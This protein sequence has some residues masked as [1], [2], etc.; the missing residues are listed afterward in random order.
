MSAAGTADASRTVGALLALTALAPLDAALVAGAAAVGLARRAADRAARPARSGPTS[1]VAGS[2]T[3]AP[4]R[5]T[6]LLTGGKM[7]K[8][9]H[10]ARAF[11][12]AGHRVV[13]VEE[14]RYRWTAHRFSRCVAAFHVVPGPHD[15]GYA[16]ALRR[17]VLAE[18]VDVVVPVCS[19]ASSVPDAAAHDL[20][21]PHCTLLHPAVDDV[22]AV[23]DK[24]RFAE[25]ASGLGLP[26]PDTHRVT[27][28]EQAVDLAHRLGG[29]GRP[30]YALKSIAYDP[31]HRLDL[32]PLPRPTRA[33]TAAFATALGISEHSPWIPQE[34]VEGVEYCTHGI[35]CAGRLRAFTCCRSSAWQ[36]T[37]EAVDHPGVRDWVQRFVEGTGLTGQLSFDIME[38]PD[39]SVVALECN[40]RPHSAV[41]LFRD[42]AELAAAYLED[43]AAGDPPAEPVLGAPP[44]YWLH[45]E[46]WQLLTRSGS[47]REHLRTLLRGRDA[48]LEPEDPLPFLA[49]WHLHLPSLLVAELRRGGSWLR[50]D[51]NI[52][53]LVQPAGD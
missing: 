8:A 3:A 41:T 23:D 9:L 34:I 28:A 49:L 6:V 16:E 29:P 46:V 12:R 40:P 11:H 36:L 47:A 10:L 19:P 32:T 52:G 43:G 42:P 38:R 31:V 4:P 15:P 7:T 27:S 44:R 26:V 13:L 35:V 39:G 22:R 5:R 21:D 1:P 30:A 33:E 53:K 25:L 37:Y 20:L 50:I 51:P 14:A 18:A 45:H 17:I 24:H 2:D 48:V